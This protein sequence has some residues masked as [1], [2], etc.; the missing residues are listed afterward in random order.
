MEQD[1]L[2]QEISLFV[3]TNKNKPIEFISNNIYSLIEKNLKNKQLNEN[4]DSTVNNIVMDIQED[5]NFDAMSITPNYEVPESKKKTEIPS[6]P[7]FKLCNAR[8]WGPEG[9]EKPRCNNEKINGC[10]FC[11]IHSDFRPYGEIDVKL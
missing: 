3:K 11:I 6:I 8:R 5:K 4:Q 9:K 10:K 1:I 2:I 7:E